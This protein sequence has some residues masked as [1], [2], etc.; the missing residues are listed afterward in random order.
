MKKENTPT[1]PETDQDVELD[2]D[3][4]EAVSGGTNPFGDIPR[5][6]NQPLDPDVRG[7]A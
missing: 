4:L 7:K 1:K 3:A 6:P 5:V 2:D